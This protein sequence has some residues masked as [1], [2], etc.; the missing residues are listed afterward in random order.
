MFEL[1]GLGAAPGA[2]AGRASVVYN[3]ADA[4]SRPNIEILVIPAASP[5][6][7]DVIVRVVAVVTDRGGRTSHA[8]TLC[9]EFGKIAVVGVGTATALIRDGDY[10]AVNG[11]TGEVTIRRAGGGDDV[12]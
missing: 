10:V 2:T 6:W 4:R 9:R 11:D 7:L 5:E 8:A 1:R 3:V 12:R